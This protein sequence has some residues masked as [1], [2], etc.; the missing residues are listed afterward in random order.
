MYACA[1]EDRVASIAEAKSQSLAAT[2]EF[3]SSLSVV[4]TLL[5][6]SSEPLEISEMKV[7]KS[8]FVVLLPVF[9]PSV[10]MSL[11]VLSHQPFTATAVAAE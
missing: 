4:G 8:Y 7:W 2:T 3:I 1:L 5:G 9:V 11:P 6:K 10:A